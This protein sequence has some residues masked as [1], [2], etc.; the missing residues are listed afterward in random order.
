MLKAGEPEISCVLAAIFKTIWEEERLPEDWQTGLLFKLPKKGDLEN[1][2]NWR[3]IM[4]LSTTSKVFSKIILNRLDAGIDPQLRNE[5]AGFRK[6]KSCSYHIFT[7]RQILEQSKE[8]NTTLYATF[9]D[10]EKA[11][12][13]VHRESLWRILRHYGIPSKIVNIIRML[14]SDFKAKVICGPQLSESFSIKTGVKQGCILSPFLFTLCIDWLMKETTKTERR[15][16]TWTLTNV[17]E[18]IDFA[19]DICLLSQSHNDMQQKTNDLNANG[20]CLGF[21]TST[22]KTKEMRMNSKSREPITVRDGT[23]EAVNDFIYLGSKMQADED[24]EPDVKRRISKDSQ[25]FSMLKNIWKSKKLSRNTKIRIFRSNVVSVLLY[26]CESWKVTTA[27][28]RKLEVFQNRCRRRILNIFW[29]N[30]IS[31]IEL[32]RKTSTSSIMTEIKRRRWTWIGHVIRMPSDAIPKIALRWTPIAGRRRRG[33]PKETWRRS[34]EREMKENGLS[35][36]QVEHLAR[37]RGDWRSLVLVL[38]ATGHEED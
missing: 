23:I 5:Q 14:Y 17:I 28:S 34:F 9:I 13:S 24:S 36:A 29:P 11:F 26:G 27:I 32:H 2:N 10:L 16:I 18:D 21:K 1:C 38:C 4:L 12:D 31:N 35:W 33:R 20:G 37:N 30:T 22:S 7:L 15:G 25:A 6:G 8:W 3:G 19:D